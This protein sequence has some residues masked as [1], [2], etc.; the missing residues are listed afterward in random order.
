M[1]WIRE[2]EKNDRRGAID[3]RITYRFADGITKCCKCDRSTGGGGRYKRTKFARNYW[4]RTRFVPNISPWTLTNGCI[5][6][7]LPRPRHSEV[8]KLLETRMLKSAVVICIQFCISCLHWGVLITFLVRAALSTNGVVA[9]AISEAALN[10]NFLPHKQS[11]RP[12]YMVR[13]QCVGWFAQLKVRKSWTS[14]FGWLILAIKWSRKFVL[15]CTGKLWQVTRVCC[16]R[17]K[18]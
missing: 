10:S 6:P 16:Y 14:S 11:Y 2:L 7:N 17:V 18:S 1:H 8:Q 4:R 9:T 12:P 13:A 15:G 5:C 3:K